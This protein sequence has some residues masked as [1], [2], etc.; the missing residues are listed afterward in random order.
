MQ[1]ILHLGG[2]G[3][4]GS[5]NARYIGLA[6]G[7][8]RGWGERGDASASCEKR[9]TNT[10]IL[11]SFVSI[12]SKSFFIQLNFE[13]RKDNILNYYILCGPTIA[14]VFEPNFNNSNRLAGGQPA[15]PQ[16][17]LALAFGGGGRGRGWNAR[18]IGLAFGGRGERA[19]QMQVNLHFSFK[20][21]PQID[22]FS[23][24]AARGIASQ[25]SR[26]SCQV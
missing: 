13:L 10:S 8:G 7:G 12:L 11:I 21:Q 17:Y 6:F 19:T 22:A 9:K 2:G 24:P 23:I 18:Y 26:R 16:I 20:N 25:S 15:S 14:K 3:E 4:G 5:W 1:V